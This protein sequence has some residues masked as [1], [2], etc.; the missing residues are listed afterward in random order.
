MAIIMRRDLQKKGMAVTQNVAFASE[1]A[2]ANND[3]DFLDWVLNTTI[4]Q[5]EEALYGIITDNESKVLVHTDPSMLHQTLEE[6]HDKAAAGV[7]EITVFELIYKDK[8]VM[9]VIAPIYIEDR[10]WGVIRIGFTLKF[11]DNE[12][13]LA[14]K[15]LSRKIRSSL[16]N[17]MLI[18]SL[19][20]VGGITAAYFIGGRIA[21]P[22]KRLTDGAKRIAGGDF[23]ERVEIVAKDEIGELAESF[24]FMA[25]TLQN[26]DIEINKNYKDIKNAYCQL[27]EYKKNLEDKV[28]ERT[29]ELEAA[30]I[31]LKN[32]QEEFLNTE[33]LAVVGEMSGMIA[34][35]ILNPM[36]S[37]LTKVEIR[38][39]KEN[40]N[41][42]KAGHIIEIIDDWE[43]ELNKGNLQH[44]L[45]QEII[46]NSGNNKT[47]TYAE[48][49]IYIL[50]SITNQ[51]KKR[52]ENDCNDMVFIL[53]NLTRIVKIVDELRG[54][55]RRM[56]SIEDVNI[57]EPVK[58]A[59]ELLSNGIE[60]RGIELVLQFAEG[61]PS[62]R[63]DFNEL[64]QV[65]SNIIKN[66]S[67]AIS[68]KNGDVK[69]IT[70]T[71]CLNGQRV[72]VRVN[73]TGT[74]ISK[75]DINQI[76]NVGFTRKSRKEG[77]GL[78]LSISRRLIQKY[79]GNIEIEESEAEKGT[80]FL[81][82]ILT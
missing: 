37:I 9:E 5:D 12:L 48:D 64:V 49:D 24:N 53:K 61:L 63:A 73:D 23:D 70:I 78:G 18:M 34:H 43:R 76:F 22:I 45:S 80:T 55:S 38:L 27:D 26:R 57:N 13:K 56:G 29:K 66:A 44:Y 50:R 40:I 41:F 75:E 35:E 14:E 36:T 25:Q 28:K 31:K 52:C 33:R 72:E 68:G 46:D 81:I 39:K 8:P 60:K 54:M 15:R 17:N 1:T 69:K 7:E 77:T 67:Q 4:K 62:V 20:L 42:K 2:A 3:F 6:A 58:E 47:K 79:K 51:I 59:I 74:G 19:F 30:Y 16:R 65:F 71:T 32:L 11:L 10:K 82:Y 21:L